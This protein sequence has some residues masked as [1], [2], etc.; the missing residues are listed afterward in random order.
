MDLKLEVIAK[1]GVARRDSFIDTRQCTAAGVHPSDATPRL[2]FFQGQIRLHR[3]TRQRP[4]RKRL[5]SNPQLGTAHLDSSLMI[6]SAMKDSP[7]R[8]DEAICHLLE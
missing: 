1:K 8:R 4:P 3:Y 5:R 2:F 7:G 6:S